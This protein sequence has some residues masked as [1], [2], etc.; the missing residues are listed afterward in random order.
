MLSAA[1]GEGLEVKGHR[2][3]KLSKSNLHTFNL[4]VSKV[5][6]DSTWTAVNCSTQI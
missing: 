6:V 5:N 3:F 2:G 1:E 4:S